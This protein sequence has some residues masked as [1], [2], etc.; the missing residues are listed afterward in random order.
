MSS[1][2]LGYEHES[3]RP[4]FV[5]HSDWDTHAHQLGQTGSGKT[6]AMKTSIFQLIQDPRVEE[7]HFIFDR[8]GQ[9]SRDLIL[10]F[11]SPYCPD[12]V[13]ERLVYI[14]PADESRVM[15]FHPL[16]FTTEAHLFFK[17][18][19]AIECIL[20]GFENQNVADQPR[21]FTWLFNALYAEALM[22]LAVSDAFHLIYPG[23]P[24]HRAMLNALP[25]MVRA[26]WYEVLEARNGETVR[27]FESVRNR[28]KPY[29]E[30]S[31][32]RRFF[33]STTNR[34][35][36]TKFMR[37][38]KIV[39]IN[40]APQNRLSTQVANAIGNMML[41][42]I[43]ATARSAEPRDRHSTFLWLDEFQNYV[44]MDM[45]E[46]IPEVRQLK[47]KLSGLAH[48]SFS[49][50]ER[51]NANLMSL[52]FQPR[53]RWMFAVQGEDAELVAQEVASLTFDAR[54]IKD[55][56]YTRRQM[57]KG[58][59]IEYLCTWSEA[60]AQATNWSNTVGTNWSAHQGA[61]DSTARAASNSDQEG[62]SRRLG[63][64]GET[65][66][67]G[68]TRVTN[69]SKGHV[70]TRGSSAGGN[71]SRSSGG[72]STATSTEGMHE[73][74]V[75]EYEEFLEL[76][77]RSYY[78]FEEQRALWAQKIRQLKT[79][80]A[81]VKLPND[82]KLY[83]V[84]VKRYAPGYLAWDAEKLERRCPEALEAVAALLEKNFS[85]REFFVSPQEIDRETEERLER[86]LR[87]VI[88]VNSHEPQVM[89]SDEPVF[90]PAAHEG[91]R[92][93]PVLIGANGNG[94]STPVNGRRKAS[95]FGV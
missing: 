72:S 58:H 87:P 67:I 12:W 66:N 43:V 59:R 37:E 95:R 30:C 60:A 48:Q 63:M 33:G 22:N 74:L 75:P 10:W 90:V 1:V 77:Q 13:R 38:K 73:T 44:S 25:P 32:T 91:N 14:N 17:V 70:D 3:R 51:G 68:S 21:T 11:A 20:R 61:S 34:F 5:R 19:R 85:N 35:D 81:L 57:L 93:A 89:E 79:G 71:E 54:R 76:S 41:N 40:L 29:V 92:R 88:T 64:P 39:L 86:I 50:L 53:M 6:E 78:S 56:L 82:P 7:C 42:E 2:L 94:T 84:D 62:V 23:S 4:F 49:Q 69:D 55:E 45:Q 26:E 18:G 65:R 31:L 36:V 15:T 83:Q 9:L 27:M 8:L 47:L 24:Y 52:I 16:Q 80:Q 46:A 28:F